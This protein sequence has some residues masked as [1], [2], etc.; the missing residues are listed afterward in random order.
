[1]LISHASL[2]SS[3]QIQERKL[4]SETGVHILSEYT[5]NS[6]GLVLYIQDLPISLNLN[7]CGLQD[8]ISVLSNSEATLYISSAEDTGLADGVD[9]LF[10]TK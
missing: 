1:M 10:T 7:G 2:A 6:H 9:R 4:T 3:M 8:C 5:Y